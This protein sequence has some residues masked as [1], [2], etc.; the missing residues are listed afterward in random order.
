MHALIESPAGH[1]LYRPIQ[2]LVHF[3]RCRVHP[4]VPVDHAVIDAECAG[5]CFR[6]QVGRWSLSDREAVEQCFVD[7][8]YELSSG[9]HS[10]YTEHVYRAILARGKTPLIVDCGANIGASVLWFSARYPE[11]HIVAIEPE[12]RNFDLLEANCRGVDVDLRRMGIGCTDGVAWLSGSGMGCRTNEQGSG[13]EVH[14]VSLETLLAD[15]PPS[16][17]EP[18]LL[19]VDIE[20]AERRLFASSP[21]VLDRFAVIALEPHDWMLPGQKTSVEF[22]R[23]HAQMGRDFSM[24]HENVFSIAYGREGRAR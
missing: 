16:R 2:K 14:I 12:P 22:F 11:A 4:D 18:F 3:L 19:K 9:E 13:I 7:K 8:Q 20:G 17:Y 15:K 21:D 1:A 6:I 23:F 24:K 10:A 5:R